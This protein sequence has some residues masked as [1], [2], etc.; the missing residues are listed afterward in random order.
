MTKYAGSVSRPRP[1][2]R[3][4]SRCLRV[5][6]TAGL[7]GASFVITAGAAAAAVPTFPDNLLV[8]PNRDFVSV[9]GYQNHVGETALL[10]VARPGVGIIGSATSVVQAG[11]VAFEV[12]HP[13]GVCWGNGTGLKITPDILPGDKVTISF[14]GSAVGD[15]TVQDAYAIEPP[16]YVAGSDTVTVSGHIGAG[17]DR[18]MLEQRTVNPDLTATSV[19]RR[20]IRA[21][22]GPMTPAPKG[23]YS[24]SLEFTGDTFTATYVFDDPATAAIAATGGGERLLSWQLVDA[25]A[26]RQGVTIAEADQLGGPGMG[27]C[28]NGPLQS[29]PAGPTD[30][31]AVNVPGGIKVTWTPAVAIP[32]TPSITGYRVT[33][34]SQTMTG[35]EQV[36]IGRRISGQAAKA[37]TITGL[38][39]TE[40]YAVEIA[41]VS[42]VGE[43]FPRVPALPVTD[44]T[45]PTVSAAPG[46]ASFA[47]PQQVTLS[48][49]EPGS[50]I[51]YTTD[52]TDPALG[53]ILSATA[54]HYTTAITISQN[55]T[56]KYFAFDPAGNASTIGTQA[57][58][59]TNTPVPAAPVFGSSTVGQNQVTLTWSSTDPSVTGFSIQPYDQAGGTVGVAQETSATMITISG[60]TA[61]TPYFFTV[62]ARNTNGY[63]PES[64]K[65][66]PLSPLGAVVA[67]AGPDQLVARKTTASTVTLTG[68]GSTA[69]A[70]YLWEQVTTGATDPDKVTLSGTATLSPSFVLPL[71]KYP[72][73]NNPL[74]FRLTVTS[75]LGV[76]TDLVSVTPVP[77]QVVIGSAKWKLGDM[78]VTGTS[79]VVGGTITVHR[80]TLTGLVAGQA[81]VTAAAAPATGGVFDMRARKA[82]AGT[83]NPTTV[84]I[85]STLGG[86]AGPFPV[87]NG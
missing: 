8:F 58:V 66:G 13:G 84:W 61:D 26:N 75:P 64:A 41:S 22:P 28:P 82:A 29:G 21:V 70:S 47:I 50:E 46:G 73:T 51:Y 12:N 16:A 37:T 17:V 69:G 39:S 3:R 2:R 18:T 31:A 7:M 6:V 44:T 19:G 87:A 63:G 71:Y 4:P 24:S 59:I 49:N 52:G 36:E 54:I 76:R 40:S 43:T 62:K 1:A 56:L 53:D 27:G 42:S 30:V 60:L 80:G 78:R 32:G 11:D 85:E 77:D 10:E 9:A 68:A 74:T 83:T 55:T 48:A 72:M 14:A 57:Y 33:A 15:T 67:N 86:T 20:D 65:I 38:S 34:V 5:G 45:P 79:T 35:N 23:G 81:A 25:A